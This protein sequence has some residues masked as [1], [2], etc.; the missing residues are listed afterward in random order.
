MSDYPE[1]KK[2]KAIAEQSQAIGEFLDWCRGEYGYELAEW[3]KS[4]KFDDR[5]MP[6]S[7][8]TEKLLAAFFD[9]DLN[10]IEAEKRAMLEKMR[11]MHE[12]ASG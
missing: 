10:K 3:D 9:I 4:R 2:L 5:M 12:E 6:V 1:H 11:R 7:E 8:S